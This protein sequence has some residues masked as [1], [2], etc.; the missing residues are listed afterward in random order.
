MRSLMIVCLLF[1]LVFP[2]VAGASG[3]SAEP[4]RAAFW[5]FALLFSV[6]IGLQAYLASQ[7]P[8]AKAAKLSEF[9]FP[10]AT[11]GRVIPISFGTVRVEGPNVI[12]YGDYHK[13]K[14]TRSAGL[15]GGSQTV[16]HKYYIG[17]QMAICAGPVT[18]KKIW[19]GDKLVWEGSKSTADR[20]HIS[21]G[22]VDGYVSFFPGTADQAVCDY[23][24]TQQKDR[25][26]IWAT[27]LNGGVPIWTYLKNVLQDRCPAYRG[28]SYVV[29][30]RGY[31]GKSPVIKPWS[32]EV[33]RIPTGLGC[34]YPAVNDDDANPMEVAYELL[35]NTEWGFYGY[36]ASTINQAEFRSVADTL[37]AEGNGFSFMLS[38]K[39]SSDELLATLESQVAGK[40]WI[41]PNTGQWRVK[42]VRDDYSV[43]ALRTLDSTNILS[44][45]RFS[46]NTWFG[47]VN[48][49]RVKYASRSLDYDS[50][51][52]QAQD[53][54]N[55]EMQG[56]IVT[57]T[58]DMPGVKDDD[59]AS[60]IA[61]REL[62]ASAY[63]LASGKFIVDRSYWDAYVGEVVVLT[64]TIGDL[65]I[66]DM[67][68]RITKKLDGNISDPRIEIE[69]VQD[70][71]SWGDSA[72][73]TGT[74]SSADV[75]TDLVPFDAQEQ[76]AIEAPYA[77]SRR[78]EVVNEGRI[79]ASGQLT[80]QGE[81][82]YYIQQ[83]NGDPPAG[84]YYYAGDSDKFIINGV[85]YSG[86]S[87]T[88]TTLDVTIA[89]PADV[90]TVTFFS[91]DDSE[92]GNN[93]TNLILVDDEFIAFKS[94][95][96][97]TDGFRL[98]GCVRGLLDS[99]QAA[100]SGGAK[101]VFLRE[102][103]LADTV[104]DTDT[105]VE[106]RLIPYDIE[107]G[108]E[109]ST[110][111]PDLEVMS[112]SMSNRERRPYPPTLLEVNSSVWP[113]SVDIDSGM[114]VE[115]NRRDFRIYN[116]VSQLTVDASTINT[117]FPS[118]YSTEY[119][120]KL[121]D[122]SDVLK[123]TGSWNGGAAS[124]TG[125]GRT[126]IIRD[127]DGL[128]SSMVVAVT[129]Q[130]VYATVTYASLQEVSV[131]V[132]VTS[133]LSGDAY[134]GICDT[135]Q[136]SEEYTAPTTGTYA[137]NLEGALASDLQVK[138]NGGTLTTVIAA[139]NTSG[140]LAGVTAGDVIE[141][142]HTDS[143]TSGE[144]LL[145]IDAPSSDDDAYA[146]LIFS[147]LYATASGGFGRGTYGEGKFG[148]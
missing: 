57:S 127:F 55:I 48:N 112:V 20:F 15:F 128:P 122:G 45:D 33:S 109:V 137:F 92:I 59:L 31:V 34:T 16:G 72:F 26:D 104:F 140:N 121:Y 12:W 126:K 85:L 39:M 21:G 113:S 130:H 125:P 23:L 32:F 145:T 82:G 102:A 7:L 18:L 71:F 60:R 118:A 22:G 98:T 146:V 115:F 40:F 86:I 50:S 96:A 9:S 106:I 97:I 2:G 148:R 27:I 119:A 24:A 19:I 61:W 1:I 13:K 29:L 90:N 58:V 84:D 111:D 46:R 123:Y 73:A 129:T 52:Q 75:D 101:V 117:D 80:G 143:S 94:Y 30:E 38:D 65:T 17:M 63:P 43:P 47:T 132:S 35:T 83:R 91:V 105:D 37:Y 136:I 25:L 49:V 88:D 41:D 81:D 54:A 103:P 68:M 44:I 87:V 14:I 138:V 107:T 66:T 139:G 78:A 3:G 67:P 133:A 6:Q 116:E 100:H 5:I 134:L 141:V 144:L 135:G 120:L 53:A 4:Q 70:V 69:V 10:T 110:S 99:A 64:Y 74:S 142:R 93:L 56:Q 28:L 95:E 79:I 114:T 36:D 76:L 11:Q 89:D 42:L 124:I 62:R 77:I 131:E 8:N 51:Y 147:N 108:E